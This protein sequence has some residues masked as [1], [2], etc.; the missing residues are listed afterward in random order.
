MA[1]NA[2]D[3]VAS[4]SQIASFPLIFYQ[5]NDAINDP[6]TSFSEIATIVNGDAALSARLLKIVNSSFYGFP[7]KIETISHAITIIGTAQLRELVL[8]TTVM[9]K[10]KGI[11]N[12]LVTMD[13][14]WR[15]SIA[16]GLAARI[17]AT[18]KQEPNADRFYVMGL[19][20]D[21]GRLVIF[22]SLSEQA[23]NLVERPPADSKPLYLMEKED[24][25]F[26]HA[27][28]GKE[29]LQA[30]KLPPGLEEAV[31][32]HHQPSRSSKFSIESVIVH[33]ADIIANAMQ[34][35]SSGGRRVP[36]LEKSAWEQLDIPTSK[37][38]DILSQ[39][40]VQFEDAIH[41]FSAE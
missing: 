21:I 11:K 22:I 40:D 5:I 30:W 33:V 10:F 37:L 2:K 3:L 4:T 38:S 34:L 24:L 6:E 18:L 28:V 20:H 25:G 8:A 32:N 29:L 39:V 16:C 7:S 23:K 36:P 12:S 31:A 41:M 13:S 35:G 1:T 19:L 14:F 17:I 26:D 9:T 27:D 15:H